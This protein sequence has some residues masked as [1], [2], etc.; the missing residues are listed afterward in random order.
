MEEAI[1]TSKGFAISIFQKFAE[2]IDGFLTFAFNFHL[3]VIQYLLNKEN[4]VI[5]TSQEFINTHKECALFNLG[6]DEK[7]SL[8]LFN[9]CVLRK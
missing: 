6:D 1:E 2:K 3:E 4:Y 8:C 9:L 5:E 7:Q